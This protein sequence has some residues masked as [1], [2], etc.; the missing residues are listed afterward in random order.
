MFVYDLADEDIFRVGLWHFR[1]RGNR[2]KSTVGRRISCSVRQRACRC[3]EA[4]W[5]LNSQRVTSSSVGHF[6]PLGWR[7]LA[8]SVRTT[9]T[10][11]RLSRSIH[12]WYNDNTATR[13]SVLCVIVIR[14]RSVTIHLLRRSAAK[15]FKVKISPGNVSVLRE[16]FARRPPLFYLRLKS[17]LAFLSTSFVCWE[18]TSIFCFRTWLSCHKSLFRS[19]S[20]RQRFYRLGYR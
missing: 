9:G 17:S 3:L 4:L 10:H 7:R 15:Q 14:K 11:V 6:R 13:I 18:R 2:S 12:S 5:L 20:A 1:F 8:R 19:K 16:F